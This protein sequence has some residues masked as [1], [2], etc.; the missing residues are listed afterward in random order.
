MRNPQTPSMGSRAPKVWSAG[1][2]G[3]LSKITAVYSTM[4]SMR[5]SGY[6]KIPTPAFTWLAMSN[7]WLSLLSR[8][9][10]TNM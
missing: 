9:A 4:G 6:I 5:L 7:K 2:P 10:R 3:A 8:G 1:E